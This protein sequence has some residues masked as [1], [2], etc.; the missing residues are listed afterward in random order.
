MSPVRTSITM[1]VPDLARFASAA[2][3]NATC[4]RNCISRS[5][6]VRRL[7]PST[8]SFTTSMPWAIGW[9]PL[10]SYVRSPGTPASSAS[11]SFSS[12][13]RPCPSTPT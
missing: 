1:T 11:Y 9:P 12:P 5:S 4:A 3:C 8:G 6:V 7:T 2:S 13:A 10:C